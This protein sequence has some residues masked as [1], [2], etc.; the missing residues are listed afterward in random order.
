MLQISN[1]SL[2]LDLLGLIEIENVDERKKLR[3]LLQIRHELKS[4]FYSIENS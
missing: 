1:F 2:S 3:D 4:L